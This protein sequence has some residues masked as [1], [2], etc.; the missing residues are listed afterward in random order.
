MDDSKSEYILQTKDLHYIYPDGTQALRKL[1]ISFEKGKKIAIIGANGAGKT[2][3]FLTLN[4]V[5]KPTGGQVFFDGQRISYSKKE[6]KDLRQKIGIVFQDSNSQL[7]SAN[8]FQ[9]VSFGP[10]NL[11]LPKEVVRE[12]VNSA[13][14]KANIIDLKNKPTHFLSGG[15]KKRVAIADILAMEPS[16]IFLDEP[17]AFVDPVTSNE[18][19]DFFDELNQ[20]GV[21]IVLSTHD[22]DRVYP[23]ADY[24]YVMNEGSLIGEGPPGEVFM[25][26]ETLKKAGLHKPLILEVYEEFIKHKPPSKDEQIPKSKQALFKFMTKE[27]SR[28]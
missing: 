1:S 6:L 26:S 21:T 19:M 13:L 28:D 12:R 11:G 17:T 23:W 15:Q 22:M 10:M 9:E 16:V 27:L 8:V 25:N 18:I 20:E 5:Y 4:G 2:T 3:L 7:F 14:E 24:V